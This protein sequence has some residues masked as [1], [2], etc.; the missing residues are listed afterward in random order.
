MNNNE[1]FEALTML[2]K[3]RG[4]KADYMLSQIEKAILIACK[5]TYG[6]NDDAEIIMVPETGEFDVKL[7][8]TVVELVSDNNREISLE[9]AMEKD[10][11][12][13]IGHKVSIDH[14]PKQ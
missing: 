14:D 3:E 8:K 13:C 2:E 4:I 7:K 9:K 5:N 10:P 6:G 1:L 12:T 11:G